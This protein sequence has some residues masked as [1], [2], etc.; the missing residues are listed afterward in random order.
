M[1]KAIRLSV[2][3]LFVVLLSACTAFAAP[4]G[5]K[6]VKLTKKNFKKY[7]EVKK[8]KRYDAFGDYDGYKITLKSKLLKKGYYICDVKNFAIKGTVKERYKYKY[9]GK[10]YKHTFK[11]KMNMTVFPP[12]LAGGSSNYNYSYAKVKKLKISKI[13]GTIVFAEPSNIIK[14]T[15]KFSTS[16]KYDLSWVEVRVKYPYSGRTWNYY[17]A[18]SYTASG[19]Y[20]YDYY[21]YG[22]TVLG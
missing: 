2:I 5:Y 8:V 10:T 11:W 6:E 9:R 18:N 20:F 19:Y 1:K 16:N 13:K 3:M 7:F 4:K 17:P 14:V 21:T 15:K 12:Y 22:T